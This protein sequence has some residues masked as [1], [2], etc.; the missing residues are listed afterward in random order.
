MKLHYLIL[1]FALG[2]LP[3]ASFST[4]VRAQSPFQLF[5]PGV[6]YLY[7]N[8]DFTDNPFDIASQYYGVRVDSLGRQPLYGSLQPEADQ[9]QCVL[10]VPSPFGYSIA[11]YAD[12]TVMYFSETDSLVIYQRAEVGTRWVARDSSGIITYGEVLGMVTGNQV[13]F[14]PDE[15]TAIGFFGPDGVTALG[16]PIIIGRETGLIHATRFYR[17]AAETEPLQLRGVSNP[18]LGVQLPAPADYTR[19]TVGDEFHIE[20]TRL[21]RDPLPDRTDF[22][23]THTFYTATILSVD[24]V[25]E[26]YTTFTYRGD[27]LTYSTDDQE[28]TE[29]NRDSILVRDTVQQARAYALPDELLIQPGARTED[30]DRATSLHLLYAADSCG[31]LISRLSPQAIFDEDINCGF[32]SAGVDAVPGLAYSAYVPF[33]LD[34][35]SGQSGPYFS[36]LRYRN[37]AEGECGTP[38]NLADIIIGVREFDAAFDA[39]F[40]V[41]PNPTSG[42]LNVVLPSTADYQVRLYNLAGSQVQSQQMRGGSRQSLFTETLP[43]GS[44]LLVVFEGTHAVARRKIMVK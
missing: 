41:F 44:Y 1:Y 32:N 16:I 37:T 2:G 29:G 17:L 26:E 10:K 8:T 35:I 19:V 33:Y 40:R 15:Y 9:T 43:A 34:Y 27:V 18:I 28:A 23:F 14:V 6:Q 7:E 30:E 13:Y 38:F 36:Q 4:C 21:G 39:Q 3:Q 20:Q 11:Q 42:Q 24:T 25:D 22:Y 5:R 31:T 12:S